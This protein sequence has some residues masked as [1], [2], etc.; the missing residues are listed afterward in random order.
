MAPGL[1]DEN[2]NK[3]RNSAKKPENAD[4]I[5]SRPV[6]KPNVVCGIAIPLSHRNI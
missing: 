4:L 3:K 1:P 5:I 2:F 6:N